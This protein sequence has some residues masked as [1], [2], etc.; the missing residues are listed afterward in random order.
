MSLIEQYNVGTRILTVLG[1]TSVSLSQTSNTATTGVN[2]QTI[3]RNE[4]G[5]RRYYSCKAAFVGSFVAASS[6]R[7]ATLAINVE[8]SSDGTS[9]DSYATGTAGTFGSTNG[10]TH[11]QAVST[12][13]NLNG[14]RRYLRVVLPAPTYSDC[15]SGQGV[16]SGMGVVTFGGADELPAQ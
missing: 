1:T 14:A 10:T 3:D 4:S 9:W 7:T 11:Y 12:N 15:S 2:G 8:H 13:V 6:Q 5:R 16:F